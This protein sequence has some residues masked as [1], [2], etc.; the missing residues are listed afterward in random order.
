MKKKN[1][2]RIIFL[3]LAILLSFSSPIY[4]WWEENVSFGDKKQYTSILYEKEEN[5]TG[6]KT[7]ALQQQGFFQ[8]NGSITDIWKDEEGTATAPPPNIDDGSTPQKMLSL[9]T[10]KKAMIYIFL[11]AASYILL[12]SRKR[13]YTLA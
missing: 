10:S 11:L 13:K 6:G 3:P 5:S 7:K 12:R 4:G 9:E 1:K 8:Q 2:Y